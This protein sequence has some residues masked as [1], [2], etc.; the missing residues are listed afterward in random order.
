MSPESD[1]PRRKW[2]WRLWVRDILIVVAIFLLW[3]W[4]QTRDLVDRPAPALVGLTVDGSAYQ[5]MPGERPTLVHFWATWCPICRLE[6]DAID[7]IAAD[8]PVITV[9][10]QSGTASELAEYLREHGLQQPVLLDDDGRIAADWGVNGVPM[11]FVVDERGHIVAATAGL[12]SQWGLRW[13]LWW[14]GR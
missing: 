9:A 12:S 8:H 2:R 6:Q 5:L 4:W 7:D 3:Q 14:A 10:T 13:R 11:S 1:A